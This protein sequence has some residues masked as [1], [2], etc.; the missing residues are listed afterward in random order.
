M[1]NP[2]EKYKQQSV[3]TMTQGEMVVR[4][5]EEIINQLSRAV[6]CIRE[7]DIEGT[8]ASLQKCQRIIN[9]LK[10]TLNFK[11]EVSSNL[12]SLYDFFNEQII[13]SNLKKDTQPIEEIL[14]LVSELKDT[15]AQ[16]ERLSRMQQ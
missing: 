12:S 7:K 5:Y 16:G 3:M 14:P 11:Y 13:K 15:F 8:N 10:S 4:L 2:Y 1:M 9:Y 6:N